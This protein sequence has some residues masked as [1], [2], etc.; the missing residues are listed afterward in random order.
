MRARIK[1]SAFTRGVTWPICCALLEREFP[2]TEE[3]THE[4]IRFGLP[5]RHRGH[6]CVHP[7]S[8]AC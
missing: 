1:V 8:L 3:N 7:A 2:N 4:R 5:T 6:G